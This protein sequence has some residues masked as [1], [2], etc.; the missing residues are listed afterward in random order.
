MASGASSLMDRAA[1]ACSAIGWQ[2]PQTKMPGN[3]TDRCTNAYYMV[4]GAVEAQ[5]GISIRLVSP[6]HDNP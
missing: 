1:V 6:V 3:M 4:S 2:Q 5:G